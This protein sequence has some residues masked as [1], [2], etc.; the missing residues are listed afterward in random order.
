M[1]LYWGG[2]LCLSLHET[3][4]YVPCSDGQKERPPLY[5][6]IGWWWF[7]SNAY[8]NETANVWTIHGQIIQ[9]TEV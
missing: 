7:N 3:K 1:V 8:D 4:N 2:P 6:S 9:Y 5:M